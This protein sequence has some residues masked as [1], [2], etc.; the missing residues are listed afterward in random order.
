MY[1]LGPLGISR[2]IRF[3]IFRFE[4]SD[5][6]AF[7]IAREITSGAALRYHFGVDAHFNCD[8]DALHHIVELS[9]AYSITVF[10]GV[11]RGQRLCSHRAY[12]IWR[13]KDGMVYL[14]MFLFTRL[15]LHRTNFEFRRYLFSPLLQPCIYCLDVDP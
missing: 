3:F 2:C 10:G 13:L 14:Q 4:D 11:V 15:A 6:F 12:A 8:L 5:D 1:P 7:R 9:L